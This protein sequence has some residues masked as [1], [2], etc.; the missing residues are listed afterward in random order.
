MFKAGSCVV[1]KNNGVCI[2]ED[3]R[4]EK[5]GNLEKQDYYA[6]KLMY[7]SGSVV[8][9][10]VEKEESENRMRVPI[11]AQEA[12]KLI[13]QIPSVEPDWVYDDKLRSVRFRDALESGNPEELVGIIKSLY[14]KSGELSELGRKLRV[15]DELI[16]KKAESN[17]CGEIAYALG[18]TPAEAMNMLTS[19]I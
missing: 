14:I 8:Y 11:T 1:Y 18:I 2:I 13:E 10:P 16:M 17:L 4:R 12:K 7:E 3:I 19:A 6:L 15:S 9:V 5:F